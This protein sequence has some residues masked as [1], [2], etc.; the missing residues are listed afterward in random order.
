MMH[1]AARLLY[2][3][4]RQMNLPASQEFRKRIYLRIYAVENLVSIT[5]QQGGK[6]EDNE[7]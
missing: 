5:Y 3:F 1:K 6:Q 7:G 4:I 2:V